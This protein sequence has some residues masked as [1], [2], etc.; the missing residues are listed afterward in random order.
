VTQE[1]SIKRAQFNTENQY[2]FAKVRY[3][4][5]LVADHQKDFSSVYKVFVLLFI[6]SKGIAFPFYCI[7]LHILYYNACK[8]LKYNGFGLQV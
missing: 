3:L 5:H 2:I 8:W 4:G 6:S 7:Y 1:Q